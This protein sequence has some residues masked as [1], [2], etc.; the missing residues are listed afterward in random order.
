MYI[1]LRILH[2]AHAAHIA[3]CIVDYRLC[4]LHP[5][6]YTVQYASRTVHCALCTLYS[7]SILR[8]A[9]YVQYTP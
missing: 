4:I 2:P 9:L 7:L 6:L 5:T 1:E 8:V 3:L